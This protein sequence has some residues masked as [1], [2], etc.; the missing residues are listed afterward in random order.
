M[1]E[2][3]SIGS[4]IEGAFEDLSIGQ[5]V[6]ND[7][8]YKGDD[9]MYICG[10]CHKAKQKIIELPD[11]RGKNWDVKKKTIVRV[12]CDCDIAEKER[13]EEQERREAEMEKIRKLR[14]VS[15][16]EARLANVTLST[17]QRTKDSE[18]TY[19]VAR[20]YIENFEEMYEKKQGLLFWGPVGTGKS[21]T[22]A[23]IANELL[24]KGTPVV[25]TSFVKLLPKI[26]NFEENETELIKKLNNAKLLI[27]DD[28]GTE[29][30]TDYALEKVYNIV[31]SRYL[32]GKPLIL[33][34]NLTMSE[35]QTT[36]DTR[37]RRIYDRIFEMCYPVMVSGQS[38]R[39]TQAAER[40]D[41]MK[42]L[43]ED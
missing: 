14:S 22:A 13:Q 2:N 27:I 31:D 41:G 9:G 21:Y 38:W 12:M 11:F 36:S 33:T 7:G 3:N 19:T 16:I 8:D 15:L 34:T 43:L 4:A 23:V 37:Y 32:T 29:R 10:K 25:M 40:F 1:D 42:K 17:F 24:N 35:M 5:L 6:V 20:R 18:K 39:V 26:Q 30:S 28:L